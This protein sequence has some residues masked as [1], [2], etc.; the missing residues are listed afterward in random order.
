MRGRERCLRWIK[1]ESAKGGEGGQQSGLSSHLTQSE[2]T[3]SLF[4]RIQNKKWEQLRASFVSY[5]INAYL[6]CIPFIILGISKKHL[7]RNMSTSL[8]RFFFMN[9]YWTV[10]YTCSANCSSSNRSSGEEP[11]YFQCWFWQFLP[12]CWWHTCLQ[13]LHAAVTQPT[14]LHTPVSW[15]KGL[16]HREAILFL[17][18]FDRLVI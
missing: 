12:P 11:M 4:W 10:F 2:L 14:D 9:C 5:E 13:P 15:S 7:K 1:S 6:K 8:E 3:I 18:A 16:C 17:F